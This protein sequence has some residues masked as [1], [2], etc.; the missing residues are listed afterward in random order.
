[1]RVLSLSR[2]WPWAMFDPVVRKHLEFR[3]WMPPI[4]MIGKTIAIQ[5]AKSWDKRAISI[6]L[7]LEIDDCPPRYD[8]HPHGVIVGVVTIDRIISEEDRAAEDQRRWFGHDLGDY[9]WVLTGV[10]PLPSEVLCTGAQGLRHLSDPIEA[11][12]LEQ[13]T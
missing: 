13:L 9:A 7:E 2:P 8:L 12:V 4:D 3:N 5:A 11:Q 1:V 10:T 6:F